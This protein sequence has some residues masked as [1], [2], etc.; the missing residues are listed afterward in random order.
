M[1]RTTIDFG[2]DLGTTNSTIAVIDNVDARV[3]PNK[4]GSGTTP[5]AVYI[6]KRGNL[7]IG[8]ES[9]LRALGDEEDQANADLEFKLR[10]GMGEEGGKTFQRSGRFLLPE[11]LS[12]EVLKELKANVQSTMGEEVR[13]AVITI[14]AAFENPQSNATQKAA[15]LAGFG[16]VPLLLE[17]IA[18]SLAHGFQSEG[19]NLYW[20]V[21]DFGG[22]TFDAALMQVRDGV[23]RVVTHDGDNHLGGKLLDWDIVGKR[24]VPAIQAQFNLPGF[25]RGGDPRWRAALGKMKYHAELAKIEVCRTRGSH[26]LW[27]ENL[28]QDADGK[29]VDFAYTLTAED[30]EEISRP[31]IERSLGLCRQTLQ[32]AG[33][34]GADMDSVLMVG[35]TT[36]N[37]W[38]RDAVASELGAKLETGVDPITVVA[39]GAAIFASIQEMPASQMVSAPIEAGTWK[40]E[41]EHRPVG[42]VADP[43]I[44]GRVVA[45]GGE[46]M[47]GYTVEFLDAKT[48]WRSGRIT[49]GAQGV[50]MTKLFAEKM[51]RHEFRLELRDQTGALIPTSPATVSYTLGVI[52]E[53]HPPLPGTISVGLANG[54]VAIYLEKGDKLPARRSME[55]FSTITLRA[56]EAADKLRIPL[57]EGEHLRAE[58]NHGIGVLEITGADIKRDLP[59]GSELQI[60]LIMD[61]SQGIRLSASV[62][63]LDDDFEISFDSLM[64]HSSLERLE[65]VAI[66]QKA[67]LER[68]RADAAEKELD[69]V[70][71]A[72]TGI[73]DQQMVDHVD[74]LLLAAGEDPDALAELDRRLRQ[75]AAALDGAEDIVEWPILLE[76]AEDARK[77]AARVVGEYGESRDRSNLARLEDE[78]S[79]AI[80]ANDP[81]LVRR[82][83]GDL[84]TIYFQV[85]DAQPG[86]HY[87]RLDY[88]AERLEI[89]RDP[90]QG[91]LLVAKGRQA[92]DADDLDGLKATLRQLASLLPPGED[93]ESKHINVGST[94][95]Q[96]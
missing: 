27:I 55:H 69:Q 16:Q 19:D 93:E 3:I 14:P 90:A 95:A 87:G 2:I 28:C 21:Y 94:M 12:A 91:E 84:L 76:Q 85:L 41:I 68:V 56:G 39:R 9:K 48:Q 88:Y 8:Q 82:S 10:M 31:Y 11:E 79:R 77:D 29:T 35:G 58:R 6:D 83:K 23:I 40:I 71:A 42:N 53:E 36:L 25:Q 45:P 62:P 26:E 17:P 22:G 92:M 13:S 20:L 81:D 32:K 38:V 34:S 64:G 50:F 61:A 1:T 51:R 63:A 18:A 37:P 24:M 7:H 73:E 72:I 15:Q 60:A 66:E 44:G 80:A 47:A 70:K 75:L 59:M 96:G 57:L 74:S 33:M 46:D 5:S 54:S 49:L 67:R 4:F 30:M 89:L 86:W 65:Q 78:L 52:P 43:D